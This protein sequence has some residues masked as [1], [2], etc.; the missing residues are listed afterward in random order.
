MGRP[1]PVASVT[2]LIKH[3]H[4]WLQARPTF[5]AVI[6]KVVTL[7]TEHCWLEL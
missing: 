5:A 3:Y 6:C 2:I 7:T 4:N 1:G